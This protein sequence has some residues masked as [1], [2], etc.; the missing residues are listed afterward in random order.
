M[1]VIVN[2]KAS[3]EKG[4]LLLSIATVRNEGLWVFACGYQKRPML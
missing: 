3:L 1:V 2:E 4:S